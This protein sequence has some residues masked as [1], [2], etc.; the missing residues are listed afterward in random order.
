MLQCFTS[1]VQLLRFR[2]CCCV[3]WKT[4][5]QGEHCYFGPDAY[6]HRECEESEA[7]VD[8]NV[9]SI[10]SIKS[11]PVW[12]IHFDGRKFDAG[13][14]DA[15]LSAVCVAGKCERNVRGVIAHNLIEM[16][17]IVRE[18]NF[19]SVGGNIFERF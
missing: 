6:A 19:E 14:F 18:E 5:F 7:A 17:R 11:G 8:V 16:G 9:S 3:C 10:Y 2:L 4:F 15:E 12:V 13:N 1:W